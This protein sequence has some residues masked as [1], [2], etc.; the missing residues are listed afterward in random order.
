FSD[1]YSYPNRTLIGVRNIVCQPSRAS[2]TLNTTF[3]NGRRTLSH[4]IQYL[5]SI[6]ALWTTKVPGTTDGEIAVKCPP[7]R[8]SCTSE[9]AMQWTRTGIEN[10]GALNIYG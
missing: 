7:N 3:V 1:D 6:Q 4:T 10:F 9:T 8:L 5:G 2:Y